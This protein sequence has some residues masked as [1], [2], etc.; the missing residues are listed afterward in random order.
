MQYSSVFARHPYTSLVT[1][2]LVAVLTALLLWLE[3]PPH[4]VMEIT[5]E[6]GPVE[7]PSAFLWFALSVGICIGARA[8]AKDRLARLAMS[9]VFAAFGARE[10]DLHKAYTTMSILKSRFYLGDAPLTQKLAGLLVIGMLVAAVLFLLKRYGLLAW[11]AMRK[12]TPWAFAIATFIATLVL[13]K[14]LD[15]AI[16]GYGLQVTEG[17]HALVGAL[18]ELL[19]LSLPLVAAVGFAL[20]LRPHAAPQAVVRAAA[21]PAI[22]ARTAPAVDRGRNR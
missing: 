3:L 6:G 2:P 13:A 16:Y 21:Q 17:G 12:P 18:E 19:E 4:T 1:P 5:G 22:A 20:G 10:L 7:L 14:V 11:R 9:F 8:P 15:R